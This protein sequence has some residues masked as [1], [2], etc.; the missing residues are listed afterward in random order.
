MSMNLMGTNVSSIVEVRIVTVYESTEKP[1]ESL[2]HGYMQK[3][4][5]LKAFALAWIFHKL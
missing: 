3:V 1:N 5:W 2:L 4:P